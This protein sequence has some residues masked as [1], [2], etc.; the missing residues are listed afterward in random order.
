MKKLTQFQNFDFDRFIDGKTLVVKDVKE[1]Y[2]Y[3][4]G[5]ITNTQL[6]TRVE[7]LIIRDDTEYANPEDSNSNFGETF[8]VKVENKF[9]L[10]LKF[11]DEVHIQGAVASV[12][13]QYQ[14]QLSV[15][16]KNV[17]AKSKAH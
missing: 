13:G 5:Q 2:E 7:L 15:T 14:N 9:D 8:S 10:P 17:L 12:Y 16:A 3:Q 4:D 11:Q 6:G 1:W